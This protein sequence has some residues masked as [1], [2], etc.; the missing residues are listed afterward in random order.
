MD[1]PPIAPSPAPSGAA[2]P[3]PRSNETD[4]SSTPG[5]LIG[6]PPIFD[7]PYR[8]VYAI[9]TQD[10]VHVYD[11]QQAKPICVV[12]NLHYATFTDLSW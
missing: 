3:S 9:A 11:T 10:A 2:A 7:L 12:S 8:L 5:P 4:G 1:P 6:P